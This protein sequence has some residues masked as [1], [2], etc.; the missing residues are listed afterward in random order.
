MAFKNCIDEMDLYTDGEPTS[1]FQS[2][3]SQSTQIC[4]GPPKT[5]LLNTVKETL[6]DSGMVRRWT[7]GEKNQSKT[8]T[9]M[10]MGET[11]TGKSTLINVMVN[12]I[13]GVKYEDNIRFEII[14]KEERSQTE[15]QTSG[16][17]V[18]E[19]YGNEGVRVPFSLRLI[20][21][22]G[23]MDTS[24]EKQDE[25][26]PKNISKLF[27]AE[28]GVQ[29]IDA[30]CLVVKASQNRLT[31]VQVKIFD[32]ILSLFGKDIENNIMPL[33][34]FSDGG[35]KP[36]ALEAIARAGVPC[37]RNKKKE[38]IFFKFNNVSKKINGDCDDEGDDD[39]DEDDEDENYWQRNWKMGVKTMQK[40]FESLNEMETRS[41]QMTQN[42]LMGREQ[43]EMNIQCLQDK[44]TA[45]DNLQIMLR[46]TQDVLEKHKEDIDA[47]KD[48]DY[49]VDEPCTIK[50]E[51]RY[52]ATCCAVCETNCHYPCTVVSAKWLNWCAVMKGKNCTVCEKKCRYEHH[53]KEK[54]M[55]KPSTR[56]VTKTFEK[57]KEQ[58]GRASREKATTENLVKNLQEHAKN[59]VSGKSELVEESYW[60]ILSLSKI[61]L[62]PDSRSTVQHLD[63]LLERLKETG[64][65]EQIQKIMEIKKRARELSKLK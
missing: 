40:F 45:T 64:T 65:K 13:L 29:Q 26:I 43:L 35:K 28:K 53:I 20:D 22:P 24:G 62:R 11:G 6:D 44:I 19:I 1:R 10:M 38:P 25:K 31:D 41:L 59:V 63:F 52:P 51:T 23:Y 30:V 17:T 14:K 7:F 18:Y 56:R 42:V 8:R 34:T 46:Q 37:A 58:Y 16:I 55:Y 2:L 21:T 3:I 32:A 15:S 47:N 49:V 61:A 33:I 5:F 39:D 9:I 54:K 12:Y 60:H 48:F 36:K 27:N 4:Q 50:V 57:M